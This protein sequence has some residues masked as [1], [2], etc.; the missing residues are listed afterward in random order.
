MPEE[1][2]KSKNE[3][4]PPPPVPAAPAAPTDTPAAIKPKLTPA[5]PTAAT[6]DLSKVGLN[7]LPS[8]IVEKGIK[9]LQEIANPAAPPQAPP[10]PAAQPQEKEQ[11]KKESKNFLQQFK[12]FIESLTEELSKNK[13]LIFIYG[14][15]FTLLGEFFYAIS[16]TVRYLSKLSTLNGIQNPLILDSPNA[17]VIKN[18]KINFGV[19]IGLGSLSAL[20]SMIILIKTVSN[21]T[22][23]S[24]T[25]DQK[26]LE[27]SMICI[28]STIIQLPVIISLYVKF[29]S[30]QKKISDAFSNVNNRIHSY[31][32]SDTSLLNS[33]KIPSFNQ[34]TLYRNI[35]SAINNLFPLIDS[36]DP[37][38]NPNAITSSNITKTD[39]GVENISQIVFSINMYINYHNMVG[40][41]SP[42]LE[43]ALST[44]DVAT[45]G[46]TFSLENDRDPINY[47]SLYTPYLLDYSSYIG[48]IILTKLKHLL[49][50][51]KTQQNSQIYDIYK[52]ILELGVETSA[53]NT[54]TINSLLSDLDMDSITNSYENLLIGAVLSQ[55]PFPILL[56]VFFKKET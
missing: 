36:I 24:Q 15:I 26:N 13:T 41:S 48:N 23:A 42:Y 37:I 55:L 2:E 11:P 44:F 33:L 12:D 6:L 17:S 38:V 32:Y 25:S 35:D 39:T 5:A 1:E 51:H 40:F 34:L 30:T 50:E 56:R 8:E 18:G 53:E 7:N 54:D 49:D 14:V 46:R 21:K 20:A 45:P 4:T 3:D 9:A 22:E 10:P 16:M 19:I 28:I 52:R 47:F 43:D 29:L 31:Y 27:Y